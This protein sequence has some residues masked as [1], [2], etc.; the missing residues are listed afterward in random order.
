V[1]YLEKGG[2]ADIYKHD[3]WEA[4]WGLTRSEASPKKNWCLL[5]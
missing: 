5:N 1:V 4:L 2:R 3:C